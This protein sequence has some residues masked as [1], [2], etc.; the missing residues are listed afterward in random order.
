MPLVLPF[1]FFFLF[2]FFFFFFFLQ[3]TGGT[4]KF[5]LHPGKPTCAKKIPEFYMRPTAVG[6]TRPQRSNRLSGRIL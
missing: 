4:F 3:A 2:F 5:Q 1:L 6:L